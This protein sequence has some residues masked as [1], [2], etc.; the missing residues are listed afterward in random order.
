MKLQDSAFCYYKC[1]VGL[2]QAGPGFSGAFTGAFLHNVCTRLH[3][4]LFNNSSAP[5]WPLHQ[6]PA[7]QGTVCVTRRL[8]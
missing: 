1:V 3:V 6:A 8:L 5:R 2:F 4:F 7:R